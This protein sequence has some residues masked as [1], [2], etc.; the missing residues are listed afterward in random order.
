MQ[1][2]KFGILAIDYNLCIRR[3]IKICV[4]ADGF[5]ILIE[6]L[7]F[8]ESINVSIITNV[9][10]KTGI[11]CWVLYWTMKFS[12]RNASLSDVGI[13]K[14][15]MYQDMLSKP[16]FINGIRMTHLTLRLASSKFWYRLVVW[17]KSSQ[18]N[19]SSGKR[20]K[21]IINWF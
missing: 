9:N 7:S 6:W 19:A 13:T 20:M 12:F 4:K 1:G 10:V 15:F 14:F 5:Q 3:E 2:G 18:T 21:I 11:D 16:E 8:V 17:K